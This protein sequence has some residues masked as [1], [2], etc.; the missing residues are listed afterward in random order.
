M[1]S[2]SSSFAPYIVNLNTS[3]D[4]RAQAKLVPP[5]AAATAAAVATLHRSL[6]PIHAALQTPSSRVL[7]LALA[8]LLP[9][10]DLLLSSLLAN[11]QAA[12]HSHGV[13]SDFVDVCAWH[14]L[15]ANSSLLAHH[16]DT[17]S[18]RFQTF[19]TSVAERLGTFAPYATAAANPLRPDDISPDAD[20]HVHL[21]LSVFLRR[22]RIVAPF[23]TRIHRALGRPFEAALCPSGTRAVAAAYV[24]ADPRALAAISL[25]RLRDDD[26]SL[27]LVFSGDRLVGAVSSIDLR[28]LALPDRPSRASRFLPASLHWQD[29]RRPIRPPWAQR[30]ASPPPRF[31]PSN[32]S[33]SPLPRGYT[34]RLRPLPDFHA[35]NVIMRARRWRRRLGRYLGRAADIILRGNLCLPLDRHDVLP[36]SRPN[37]PSCFSHPDHT[38][39][40]DAIVSEYLITN[41]ISW[42]PA[43]APPLCVCPISVV[44]KKTHPFFRLVIDARGP[45]E[46][47]SRWPANM[48]SLSSSSHIFAPGS[49][50]FSLDIGKAYIVSPYMGCYARIVRRMRADGRPYLHVGCTPE[51]CMLNCSKGMLGFR[52]RGQ[53]FAF[54]APMF[55]AKVSGNLLDCLLEPV[56]R[57]IRTQSVPMLR[58]VDDYLCVLQPLPEHRHVTVSCGG[59]EGGCY[60]CT[61]TFRRAIIFQRRLYDLLEDLGF[62]FSEKR[63]PPAQR[64]EFLGLGWDS[65]S[66]SFWMTSA[67]ATKM[68][69]LASDILAA[70][71][72]SRRTL[73]QLRGRLTWFSACLSGVPL[74]TRAIN[75]YIGAPRN[76]TLWDAL[77]P[78]PACV[79]HEIQH[80][81]DTL[82]AHEEHL[83]PMWKL[84]PSQ[85]MAALHLNCHVVSAY[86]ETDASSHGW[87]ARLRVL[88]GN[89]TWA[90]YATS[91]PWTATD[92]RVQVHCEA[93]AFLQA[94]RTFLPH[95]I[96]RTLLHVT[97]C[98]AVVSLPER[99][100]ASSAH[101]QAIALDIWHLTSRHG[102]HVTSMWVPGTT[103]VTTGTDHLSRDALLDPHAATLAPHG[104][105]MILSQA[106]HDD[107]HLEIDWFADEANHLLDTFWSR[108]P[109]P[110]A[111]G[112][113]AFSAP[114]WSQT[115][116]PTCGVPRRVDGYFFPPPP[117]LNMVVARLQQD[118]ASGIIIVP[119]LPGNVWW[120]V[121]AQAAISTRRLPPDDVLSHQ[122]G[123]HVMYSRYNWNSISFDFATRRQTPAT[124]PAAPCSCPPPP[125]S[126]LPLSLQASIRDHLHLHNRLAYHLLD[127]A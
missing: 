99:G 13:R 103:M 55:G 63:T 12:A 90:S 97:D 111:T 107:M 73:A 34:T 88:E 28:C 1:T 69:N 98:A 104:W 7:R 83:R 85:H 82:S 122:P 17:T 109:M 22:A 10:L 4:V 93:A 96:G 8:R 114:S 67:K 42:Y 102:I 54:N 57:W 113:D 41:V 100:S 51:D 62:T 123:C 19:I 9:A 74:L 81:H 43:D 6:E 64:G 33:P 26:P 76:S 72:V 121:L 61:A 112:Q 71:A 101:L 127:A 49:V 37:L 27:L 52:W 32:R 24:T 77:E 47:T 84:S 95:L 118:Q 40:I 110:S 60:M 66:C 16:W 58:W 45:N 18:L 46:A 50:A 59:H 44:P 39:F 35:S 15:A 70:T 126:L 125:P 21:R 29:R 23:E 117:I 53:L 94:L 115:F 86:L 36:M 105:Q 120:P 11:Q 5:T 119:R 87:G 30:E 65:L 91:V 38:E 14:Y 92:S 3:C 20:D 124:R 80:W 116:C 25:P 56:D 89:D 79:R 78:I 31:R 68:A 75:K 106:E 2:P 108:L 48:R